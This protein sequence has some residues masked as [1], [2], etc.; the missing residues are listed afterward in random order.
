MIGNGR[1][2]DDDMFGIVRRLKSIDDGY[3]VVL[4]YKTGKFEVHNSKCAP[5][6]ICLVLP[7]DTLDE[8]TV[9]R[10]NMTRAERVKELLREA[11]RDN[12]ILE[13][14]KKAAALDR[15]QSA[16]GG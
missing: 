4:N 11:E 13:R 14:R 2:I 10:V 5:R 15:I 8:R 7:F 1:I 3:F 9:R 16:V 12:E 6:T